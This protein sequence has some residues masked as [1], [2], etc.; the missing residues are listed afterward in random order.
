MSLPRGLYTSQ[1]EP[2]KDVV[3]EA[4]S[5]AEAKRS[6]QEAE[7]TAQKAAQQKQEADAAQAAA[8][9]RWTSCTSLELRSM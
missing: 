8:C 2:L 1:M 9:S 6:K 5:K 4:Q 3:Y 7:L